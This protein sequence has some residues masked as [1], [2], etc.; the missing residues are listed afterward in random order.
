MAA[1]PRSSTSLLTEKS[2]LLASANISNRP[3]G[4]MLEGV[5]PTYFFYNFFAL[6]ALPR[7]RRS[8]N[9][10]LQRGRARSLSGGQLEGGRGREKGLIG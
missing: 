2:P 3:R 4:F 5:L 9:H 1:H 8:R 6:R 10:Y 7:R